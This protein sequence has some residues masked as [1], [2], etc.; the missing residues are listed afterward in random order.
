[1][2]KVVIFGTEKMAE[3]AHFYFT[4]DS[5]YEPVAFTVDKG[6]IKEGNK[7]LGL[8]IVPF[9]EIEKYY[10]SDKFKMFV[11][12]GYTKLN[13]IRANKYYEAK[14]KGYEL[15]NYVSSKIIHWGDTQIGDNCFIFENQVFQ[16]GVK[17]GNNV[18]IW[19]GNH[20][21]HDV[22]VGDHSFIASHVIL[23]GYVKVGQYCF[24]GINAAVRDAVNIASECIIGAGALILNNTKEKEVY[25]AKP[26]EKYPLDSN[27]FERMMDI[28]K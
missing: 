28:S 12:I 19:S 20:F 26:T 21:G 18:I 15:V 14:N 16:P 23:S 24:I 17:I 22:V 6:Y 10:P 7:F 8:P 1:M 9:E 4:K 13:K 3:L 11:A 25:I 5:P 27:Q 2:E